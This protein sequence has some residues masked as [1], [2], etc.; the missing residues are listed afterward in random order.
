MKK[1][2]HEVRTVATSSVA[3]RLR[4]TATRRVWIQKIFLRLSL[5]PLPV[6]LVFRTTAL[7]ENIQRRRLRKSKN[8]GVLKISLPRT[9][10]RRTQELKRYPRRRSK[11]YQPSHRLGGGGRAGAGQPWKRRE[12]KQ[13]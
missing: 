8:E 13:R 9:L 1:D 10:L 3:M 6:S 4:Q 2:L 7:G 12:S 5:W 11:K